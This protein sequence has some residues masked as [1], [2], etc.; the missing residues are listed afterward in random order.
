MGREVAFAP[1]KTEGL[2]EFS[3]C[4]LPLDNTWLKVE[5]A[6]EQLETLASDTKA[7]LASNPYIVISEKFTNFDD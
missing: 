3:G 6:E 5:R 1:I 7:F 2:A 4:L